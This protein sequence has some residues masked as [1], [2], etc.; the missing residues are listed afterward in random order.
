MN[1]DKGVDGEFQ[2]STLELLG[3]RNR[4]SESPV[5]ELPNS[6]EPYQIVLLSLATLYGALFVKISNHYVFKPKI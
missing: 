2:F 6:F 3:N 1:E 5:L 4:M